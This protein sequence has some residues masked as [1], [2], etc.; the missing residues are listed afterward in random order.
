MKEGAYKK[1][2]FLSKVIE[3]SIELFLKKEC[4]T[5]KN[6][7]INISSSNRELIKGEINQMKITAEKV[8]YKEFLFNDIE[9]QTN[10]LRINYQ[11]I[12][13]QLKS[14]DN[15][16]VRI[17]ISLTGESLK[18]I[19]NSKNWAWIGCLISEKLL[20][21]SQF[22]DLKIENNIIELKGSNRNNTNHKTE[23][24][25]IKSKAGKIH[26]ENINNMYSMIIPIEDK[27]HINHI[28]IV[29][30]IININAQS[31]ASI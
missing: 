7:N 28:N 5:I 2:G 12:N 29:E 6:I 8:N 4:K 13:K 16:L 18:K 25:Q 3:K 1:K 31:E 11:I 27:I 22:N 30:N 15:F 20:N 9:L 21:T 10:K 19:L 17:K 14:K 26:L 23:L 24:I